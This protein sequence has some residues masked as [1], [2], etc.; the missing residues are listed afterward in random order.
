MKQSKQIIWMRLP[1]Q[2][3]NDTD[4]EFGTH[5]PLDHIKNR[6]SFFQ[7]KKTV[8]L[9]PAG[10]KNCWVKW[11]FR[12]SS[13]FPCFYR[14]YIFVFI[15]FIFILCLFIFVY[16]CLCMFVYF[17]IYVC[18]F[19]YLCSF[20]CLFF[21]YVYLFVYVCLFFIPWWLVHLVTI[22]IRKCKHCL[23]A[24]NS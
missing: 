15:G 24:S 22:F 7:K 3:K 18:L 13:R 6:F 21:V 19:V 10:L 20:F 23:W 1:S 11:I 8:N 4:L 12:I 2:T 9:Q 5:T 16:I 14:F 17:F